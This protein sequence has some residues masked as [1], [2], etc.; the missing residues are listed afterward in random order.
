V[1]L[2]PG[3]ADARGVLDDLVANFGRAMAIVVNVLDPDV[4]VLG[5]GVSNLDVLYGEG[6][7]SVERWVFNDEFTTP[8]V[9]N[10]LG[11]SAGVIG[12]AAL[13]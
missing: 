5:G 7:S 3:D 13:L 2:A 9:R 11:D 4:I 8:I 12:A 10:T 6:R 1:S